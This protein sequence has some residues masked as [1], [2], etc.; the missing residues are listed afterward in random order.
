D[1][2][3]ARLFFRFINETLHWGTLLQNCTSTNESFVTLYDEDDGN[4][5]NKFAAVVPKDVWLGLRKSRENVTTWSDGIPFMFNNS[6]V[7]VTNG[8]P[9]CEGI[10]QSKWT[11]FNCSDKKNF[12]CYKGKFQHTAK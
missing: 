8:M 6:D 4:F 10:E 1:C 11:V 12:M 2:H 3:P 7:T 9:I 5:L